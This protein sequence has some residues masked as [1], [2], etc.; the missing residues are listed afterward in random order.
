MELNSPNG[1][2]NAALATTTIGEAM[3]RTRC[4]ALAALSIAYIVTAVACSPKP[5]EPAQLPP[6]N[7]IQ[8]SFRWIPNDSVDL[9]SPEGT[10]I[11][12]AAE[13][14]WLA[15]AE[16]GDG[17]EAITNGGY[18]GFDRVF[19]NV[20]PPGE[21]GG[22]GHFGTPVLGTDYFEVID[23]SREGDRVTAQYCQYSSMT[24]I[25]AS[26]GKYHS[27][28]PV[29]ISG[30]GRSI[31]FGPDPSVAPEHQR[32]PLVDQKG[33]SN[34]PDVNV[35]GTWVLFDSGGLKS[36]G[37]RCAKTAPNTPPESPDGYVGNQ[38]PP[39]L[40]PSPGWPDG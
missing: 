23:L 32:P 15:R 34:R 1:R 10:F 27:P 40:P 3:T 8:T 28:G 35:F 16:P 20:W 11:R 33:P 5:S 37:N 22:A 19:N 26:D 2:K 9:M 7:D 21:V 30:N 24:A 29:E 39:T 12:A 38:P 18:P 4:K 6:E 13:S 36:G 25:K 14:W 17:M 31:T